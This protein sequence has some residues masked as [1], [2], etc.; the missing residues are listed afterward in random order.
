[1]QALAVWPTPE[2]MVC[3]S[4]IETVI[5]PGFKTHPYTVRYDCGKVEEFVWKDAESYLSAK[6]FYSE[7]TKIM[8]CLKKKKKNQSCKYNFSGGFFFFF[9]GKN[10]YLMQIQW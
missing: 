10:V 8:N 6:M 7:Q 1:M 3:S 9:F 5:S 4:E 2:N